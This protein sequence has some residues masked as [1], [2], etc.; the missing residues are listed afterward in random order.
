M[1][2]KKLLLYSFRNII[3]AGAYI[4]T[5][6][7]IMR[8][9]DKIFG[10]IEDEV[11]GPFA[12][13]MLFVLSAAIVGS[14]IFGQAVYYFFDNRKKDSILMIFYSIGCLFILTTI[15]FTFLAIS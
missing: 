11:L 4:F 10:R 14:L 1:V 12:I 5:V 9:G 13:L 3:G 6:S 2:N 15:I 7:Q 8:N